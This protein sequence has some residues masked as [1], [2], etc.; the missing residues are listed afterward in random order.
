[1][2]ARWGWEQRIKQYADLYH[3]TWEWWNAPERKVSIIV[4]CHNLAQYLDDCLKSVAEQDFDDWE[5]LIIDDDSKDNTA[6]VAKQWTN[7]DE[8]FKYIK[9]PTNLKLPGARNFGFK[10]SKGKYILPLDADDM[11]AEHALITLSGALD[12]DQNIHIAYGHLDTVREDG[13]GRKKS[14]GWPFQGY[15]WYG[16]MAH[17]NQLPY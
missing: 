15:S 2:L 17:L 7:I 8:R 12:S 16:Q 6:H 9:T 11:L 10:H 5:C 3:R 4:T 1:M 14:K 13:S